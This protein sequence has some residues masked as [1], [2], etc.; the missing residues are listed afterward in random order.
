[1]LVYPACNPAPYKLGVVAQAYNPSTQETEAG[2]SSEIQG[3]PLLHSKFEASQG[4]MRLYLK[5]E[6]GQE[7]ERKQITG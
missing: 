4:Y 2:G 3:Y 6:R 7:R 1:M 5:R